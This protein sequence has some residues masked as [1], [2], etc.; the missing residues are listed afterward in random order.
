MDFKNESE[1][2]EFKKD[3]DQ[4]AIQTRIQNARVISQSQSYYQGAQWWQN[5]IVSG[6]N[7]NP[8]GT[9]RL[10]TDMNPDSSRFRATVNRMTKHIIKAAAATFPEQ[11]YV[12]ITQ[13]DS[14]P[15]IDGGYRAQVIE[16]AA[17]AAIDYTDLLE[18]C[19]DANFNRA[20]AGTWGLGWYI[21]DGFREL[22]GEQIPDKCLKAFS[23]DTTRLILDPANA[24]RDLH[25]HEYVIY[26]DAWTIDKIR[27][28]LGIELDPNKCATIGRL[29]SNELM[30]NTISQ[31]Q[32][33]AQYKLHSQTKGAM[34]SQVHLRDITGR[35]SRMYIMV[36]MEGDYKVVNFDNPETPFG[37]DGLPLFLLHG[38]RR[39][40]SP[41]SIGE[42]QMTKDDQDRINVLMTFYFRW[43]QSSA[44]YHRLV[45]RRNFPKAVT[46]EDIRRQ[47]SNRV[48]GVTIYEARNDK[49]IPEPK[50]EQFP[51][52][53]Q[54]L[55]AD[56]AQFESDMGQQASRSPMNFGV[57]FKSHV[58]DS[59]N[60]RA[61][62]EID[63][64]LGIRVKE[65]AAVYS[66]V[67]ECLVG[68]TI[69]LVKEQSPGTIV[70][71][72]SQGFGEDEFKVLL[73]SD[74]YE[75][76]CNIRVR[77]S[78]IRFRSIQSRQ[79]A[80]DQAAQLQFVSAMDYRMEQASWDVPL[81]SADNQMFQSLRLAV[82]QLLGG[83]PWRPLPL[84][85]YGEVCMNLLRRAL[86]DKRAKEN[87]QVQ[88][89]VM[90]AIVL[91]MQAKAMETRM[92]AEA[93][94]PPQPQQVGPVGQ[95]PTTGGTIGDVLSAL[96]SPGGGSPSGAT[97]P[98][99]A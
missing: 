36:Q 43:L 59:S 33:Y 9:G 58:P 32:L 39:P 47:M 52:P 72:R 12:D 71:L 95:E 91:Q 94:A 53:P 49:G 19:R 41:W 66:Q 25:Q 62:E 48:G 21:A 50:L 79:Q 27:G 42:G 35:Y 8:T 6:Q 78:S 86:W 98:V 80:L 45:D 5:N 88:Q 64:V 23:F 76:S 99:A 61:L 54:H 90:Q 40:G 24:N 30:M 28:V 46:D 97:Q 18:K 14:D 74:E 20:V 22:D 92:Q 81:T 75:P 15:G 31:N 96:N 73:A 10:W 17:N 89:A 13:S 93:E 70:F 68:T 16:Q 38:H 4:A 57:G 2:A 67:V 77:E 83:Q 34:V 85:E 29:M 87:P 82:H 7:R 69:K 63:Q 56:A 65:D 51:P 11:L 44:G 55:M 26:E 3:A 1:L 37:G 60:Q 84:G